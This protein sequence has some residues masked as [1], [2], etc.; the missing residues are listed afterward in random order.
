VAL[1]AART[2]ATTINARTT[3]RVIALVTALG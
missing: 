3:R 2:P 1:G